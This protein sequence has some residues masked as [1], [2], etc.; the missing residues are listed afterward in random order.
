[1]TIRIG[2]DYGAYQSG[3][4]RGFQLPKY[5]ATSSTPQVP[6]QLLNRVGQMSTS[7][8]RVRVGLRVID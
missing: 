3:D 8:C 5:I 4:A 1:M 2:Q 7:T 6:Q